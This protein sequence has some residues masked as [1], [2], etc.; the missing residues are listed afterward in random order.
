M[1]FD[2]LANK[3]VSVNLKDSD[4]LTKLQAILDSMDG[5]LKKQWRRDQL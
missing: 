4:A 5:S 3:S 1:D 2:T